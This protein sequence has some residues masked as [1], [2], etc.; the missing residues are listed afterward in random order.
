MARLAQE[1][2]RENRP[3]LI[4]LF[5]IKLEAVIKLWHDFIISISS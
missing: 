3:T 4:E 1:I 2:P 5:E